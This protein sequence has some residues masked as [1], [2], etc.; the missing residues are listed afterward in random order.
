MKL[1]EKRDNLY[2]LDG[3]SLI[4]RAFYA[5]RDLKNSKGFPTNAIFGFTKMIQKF[6]REKK[7]KHFVAVLDAKGPTFRHQE[8]QEYKAQRKPMPEDLRL[9]LPWIKDLLKAYQIPILEL[10]GFEADDVIASLTEKAKS[11]FDVFIISPDKDMLQL[12][13]SQVKI[14]PNPSESLVIDEDEVKQLYGIEPRKVPDLLA[15]AG[16]NSDNIPGVP[17]IGFKTACLLLQEY[18]D[19]EHILQEPWI[20]KGK[21]RKENLIQNQAIARLSKKLA[22]LRLDAP[23][24][25]E[26]SIAQL[27][28][29]DQE[30]LMRIFKEL[31]FRD[32]LKDITPEK[33]KA[34]SWDIVQTIEDVKEM[35]QQIDKTKTIG[36][37]LY[38]EGNHPHSQQLLGIS[39]SI[40]EDKNFFIPLDQETAARE[41][42]KEI[43]K[44][45][46][47]LK[48]GHDLK[49]IKLILESQDF[50]IKGLAF[51]VMIAAF[52]ANPAY[53]SRNLQDLAIHFLQRSLSSNPPEKTVQEALT[54][55][56]LKPIL[57]KAL[58]D[59]NQKQ[60]FDQIEIPLICVL[61]DMEKTGTPIDISQLKKFSKELD[62]SL[63]ELQKKI[64]TL[65]EGSFNI[66]S[67]KELSK[68]LFE[69]LK[70]PTGKKTKTGYSTDA[71][72]LNSLIH[73]H[74]IISFL[75]EYRQ[76]SKLKS[77]YVDALPELVLPQTGRLHTTFSQV[78]A[79]TGRLSSTNPNLQNIPTRSAL[80]KK[81]RAAFIAPNEHLLLSADYSQ[82][83]LRVLAHLSE[84]PGLI[85]AFQNDEDIHH[86]TA[87][88]IFNIAPNDVTELQRSKAKV[89]N[90][91]ITYGMSAYGLSKELGISIEEA[92]DFIN[93]YHQ[94]FPKVQDFIDATLEKA[95]SSGYVTTLF[96]RRRYLSDLNSPK[97]QLRQLSERMA[98]NTPIQG[99]SADLIKIAMIA[100]HKDLEETSLN[101]KLVLQI[102]DELIF[103]IPKIE[104][105]T[106]H[107]L[108]K[109]RMEN[110]I[111]LKVKLKV[112]IHTG[113]NWM[114]I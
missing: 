26:S 66:H 17:G 53:H 40:S 70:L 100:I 4:Y 11:E 92:Q 5:I 56:M 94:R 84:D 65:A 6:I 48:T 85:Q 76:I 99:T 71:E 88:A 25:I 27:Q 46:S 74:E 97:P 62:H 89:I 49:K 20:Q 50:L 31:E 57:E 79:E 103:I 13:N 45:P 59:S 77:T 109:D 111:P 82:I 83:E 63:N 110:I 33:G 67:P 44:D 10:P 108:V 2:I 52:L 41:T 22:T 95:R 107:K 19:L 90:F 16:D 105:E 37:S 12:I 30:A 98:I 93:K 29:P 23:I 8:F 64:H 87:Q 18:Q 9:Q 43:L 47:I 28:T 51:D 73:H 81:I 54:S 58:V 1:N 114:E 102:H 72:V 91:G 14:I 113:S 15:L 78:T 68:V 21:I 101:S 3:S 55:L 32:L 38:S 61:S 69:K 60:L 39:F 34:T 112:N 42:V 35:K 104:L 7:P 36:I 24:D 80:G 106:I 96:H 86:E 75:L